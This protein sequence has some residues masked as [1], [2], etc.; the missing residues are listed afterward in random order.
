MTQLLPAASARQAFTPPAGLLSLRQH[1]LRTNICPAARVQRCLAGRRL[2]GKLA[3][4]PGCSAA[5]EPRRRRVQV[6]W[7]ARDP[8]VLYVPG[9]PKRPDGRFSATWRRLQRTFPVLKYEELL[10]RIAGTMLLVGL[11]R[12]GYHM[13]LQG[14][15]PMH[16]RFTPGAI[17]SS[18]YIS[19]SKLCLSSL[20][21]HVGCR[22]RGRSVSDLS[23]IANSLSFS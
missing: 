1:S 6:C 23:L 17:L 16:G 7:A 15:P 20:H 11:V 13:P 4:R 14:V 5:R 21:G 3:A 12:L 8:S 22:C 19:T 10:K 2:A 9:P 18:D